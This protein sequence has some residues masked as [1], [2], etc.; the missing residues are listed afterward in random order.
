MKDPIH[1]TFRAQLLRMG[2]PVRRHMLHDQDVFVK[3]PR[4]RSEVAARECTLPRRLF[5]LLL[6]VDGRRTI[7]DLRHTLVRYRSLDECLDMLRAKGLI[8]PLP[9]LPGC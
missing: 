6:L 2:S 8:A 4:G 5:D 1:P 9:R 3:T 7:G